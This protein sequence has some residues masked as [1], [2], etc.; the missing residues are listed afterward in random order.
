MTTSTEWVRVTRA[1]LHH[2]TTWRRGALDNA[3]GSRDARDRWRALAADA[4]AL[5]D[6]ESAQG[7]RVA[8]MGR[9]KAGKSTLINGLLGTKVTGTHA[10]EMSAAIHEIR[11][12][13]DG[14]QGGRIVRGDVVEDVGTPKELA[15]LIEA[16]RGDSAYWVGVDALETQIAMPDLPDHLVIFDT[17][18]VATM[19]QANALRS[20]DFLNAAHVVLWVQNG[21][22]LGNAEDERYLSEIVRR[23]LSV[24]VVITRADHLDDDEEAEARAWFAQTFPKLPTPLFT[25]ANLWDSE[26]DRSDRRALVAELAGLGE[27]AET[28]DSGVLKADVTAASEIEVGDLA[29]LDV[30]LNHVA[31]ATQGTKRRVIADVRSAVLSKVDALMRER[32]V[33]I[34]RHLKSRGSTEPG[35]A[36]RR[37]VSTELS[38]ARTAALFKTIEEE[39]SNRMASALG[40]ELKRRLDELNEAVERSASSM[41]LR[42]LDHMR[43]ELN[44]L[45]KRHDAEF[46][47]GRK[48]VA[49]G[50]AA[51]AGWVAWF[52]ANAA[53]IDIGAAIS[54]VGL[55]VLAG[56]VALVLVKRWRDKRRLNE[57]LR[58][59]SEHMLAEYREHLI[60]NVLEAQFFPAIE[61]DVHAAGDAINAMLLTELLGDV[62][63]PAI[64]A[65]R[66][67]F[68]AVVAGRLD[69]AAPSETTLTVRAC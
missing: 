40:E 48:A 61:A 59:E 31:D 7:V 4:E 34:K 60:T 58:A 22:S 23:D 5:A 66:R 27:Q 8:V 18:G 64:E 47:G 33:A 17:P 15:E 1:G 39:A 44:E 50:A 9:V 24:I 69:Q 6:A 49:G 56:G 3:G 53:A 20:A 25:A 52:G 65:A 67:F 14:V 55:P 2:V 43:T 19:T 38:D 45:S 35:E 12:A 63:K 10:F 46:D 21:M 30:V 28:A 51:A 41:D 13:V 36:L 37:A 62:S 11:P 68:D 57:S 26:P 16:H 42:R 32:G 54:G 29:K